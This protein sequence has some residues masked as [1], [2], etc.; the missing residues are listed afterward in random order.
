MIGRTLQLYEVTFL[1]YPNLLP[2][3][4]N[5]EEA[6]PVPLFASTVS[7]GF[8]GVVAATVSHT[9]LKLYWEE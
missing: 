2:H 1:V 9:S 4:S 8:I 3:F 7:V 5:L 6:G